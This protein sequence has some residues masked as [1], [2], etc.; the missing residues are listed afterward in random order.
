MP[1]MSGLIA[2]LWLLGIAGPAAAQ[3]DPGFRYLFD[4]ETLG[5][6]DGDPAFWK[7]E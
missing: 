5:R 6:W 2:V 7:V 3:V 1:K 4:G